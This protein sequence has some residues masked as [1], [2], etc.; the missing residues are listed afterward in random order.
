[1]SFSNLCLNTNGLQSVPRAPTINRI[2]VTS[3]FYTIASSLARFRYVS[4]FSN[5]HRLMCHT[6]WQINYLAFMVFFISEN[7]IRPSCSYKMVCLY[8]KIPKD[9]ARV[10][11]ND[12]FW[13]ML[14]PF[15]F[16]MDSIRSKNFPMNTPSDPIMPSFIFLSKLQCG[17]LT[18][19][20][21]NTF[22]ISFALLI[23]QSSL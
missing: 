22:C 11:L 8:S 23:C 2:T 15:W 19:Q 10:I 7:H 16:N 12:R 18:H 14:I 21:Y 1:M 5:Y 20:P 13:L 9:F 4:I 6:V 3:I 17:W